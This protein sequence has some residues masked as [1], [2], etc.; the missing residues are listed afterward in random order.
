MNVDIAQ[1]ILNDTSISYALTYS[2]KVMVSTECD[3]YQAPLLRAT[4]S[5]TLGPLVEAGVIVEW[6][7][8]EYNGNI[9]SFCQEAS[10]I[11]S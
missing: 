1:L 8:I 7:C 9:I 6:F 3:T 2:D 10:R 5:A 11:A 4:I